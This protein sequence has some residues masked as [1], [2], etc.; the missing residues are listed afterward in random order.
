MFPAHK[1]TYIKN[2]EQH[3]KPGSVLD[4]HLSLLPVTRQLPHCCVARRTR[5]H[6]G[7][8]YRLLFRLASDGVYTASTRYRGSGGLLH[9]HSTLTAD[10]SAAVSF[11]LHWPWSH[12]HR[13][14]SGI[15]PYE[16]RTFL[17]FRRDH[18]CCSNARCILSRIP[19]NYKSGLASDQPA[20][21]VIFLCF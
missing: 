3:Y 5:R 9:R 8:P 1:R 13:T 16:A 4:D 10:K 2:V 18:P 14:L 7:P 19:D 20:P 17:T 6:D 21:P 15:L 11:L 12:L